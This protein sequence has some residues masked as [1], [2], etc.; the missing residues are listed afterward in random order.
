M[1]ALK[2]Y[3]KEDERVDCFKHFLGFDE[4]HPYNR[5]ILE[6]YVKVMKSSNESVQNL[7]SMPI[8]GESQTPCEKI[9]IEF[10]QAYERY[11]QIFSNS[12][13]NLKEEL[14]KHL[15]FESELIVEGEQKIEIKLNEKW[16]LYAMLMFSK[17]LF[18]ENSTT[19]N[20]EEILIEKLKIDPESNI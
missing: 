3:A 4:M 18:K 19:V 6:F 16:E 20:I 7:M 15:I 14:K 10:Q 5:D 11:I 12:S 9:Y 13:K 1:L 2:K 8:E 17:N